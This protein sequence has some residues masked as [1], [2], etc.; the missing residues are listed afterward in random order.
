MFFSSRYK[1]GKVLVALSGGVDSAVAVFLLKKAG[2]AVSAGFIR[3]YNIDGCQDKELD[4]AR[5]I[6]QHLSIPFYVFDFEKEYERRVVSYLLNGYKNGITPNPDVVCNSQIKFGLFY[7]EA[8]RMG[9]SCVASG[10][11]AAIKRNIW[12]GN[13]RLAAAFDTEKDQTYFL[14]QVPK[15]RFEHIL[16]PLGNL[17]KSSVRAIA[18]R[19]GLFVADKKDSQGVCFLGKFK[20]DD[21]LKQHIAPCAGSIIDGKGRVVGRHDGVWF[22]TIGQRHGFSN[23]AGR[24]FF[25]VEKRVKENE[26]VVAYAHDEKLLTNEIQLHQLNLLSKRAINAHAQQKSLSCFVRTRYRQPLTRATIFFEKNGARLIYKTPQL[27]FPAVGQSAVW[28]DAKG[29][30][31]GGGIIV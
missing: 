9:F 10:H 15:E 2:Y 17:K 14:W 7:E 31:L 30:V 24:E 11:Y 1:K 25:V 19:A 6:A 16:F 12:G 13:V 5:M 26:L 22:Y 21:F 28:Y 4:D 18:K 20:F 27:S 3:G 29:E 8:M 23:T